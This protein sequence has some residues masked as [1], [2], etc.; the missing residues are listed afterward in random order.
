[1]PIRLRTDG[2]LDVHDNEVALTLLHSISRAQ[3]LLTITIQFRRRFDDVPIAR[4]RSL[5][6]FVL[7]V[8][9]EPPMLKEIVNFT[10]YPW[11]ALFCVTHLAY[12]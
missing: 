3:M 12:L 5:K 11:R 1:M 6:M 9:I 10:F 2:G 8:W 7:P 4:V